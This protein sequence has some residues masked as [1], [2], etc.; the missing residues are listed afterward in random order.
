MDHTIPEHFHRYKHTVATTNEHFD[1]FFTLGKECESICEMGIESVYS[2]WAFLYALMNNNSEK[3]QM[4]CVDINYTDRVK[5]AVQAAKRAGI[6]MHIIIGDSIHTPLPQVDMLFIDTWHIYGHLRRELANHYHRVNKYILMHDTE[7]DKITGESIRRGWDTRQQ[8]F[9]SGYPEEEI[10]KG[11]GPAIE[12]FLAEHD[13]EWKLKAHYPNN[14][15]L[16]VLER[17][18][19]K[20]E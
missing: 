6:D 4:L 8:S 18:D 11:L 14:Y 5:P 20:K 7:I 19:G 16:T 3:K 17:I 10:R 1:T 9:E 12:E 13:T 2:T 15:G